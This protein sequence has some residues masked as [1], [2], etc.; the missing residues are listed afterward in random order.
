MRG[1][2]N[3]LRRRWRIVVLVL[4]LSTGL[5]LAYSLST[6]PQYVSSADVLI[7]PSGA[8]IQAGTGTKV[9]SDEMLTQAQVVTS[10]PVARLVKQQLSLSTTPRLADLVTVQTVGTSRILRISALDTSPE[11]AAR[12]ANAVASAYLQY[13]QDE[14]LGSYQQAKK[15]L[16]KEQTNAE[17]QLAKIDA[18][19]KRAS[20]ADAVPLQAERRALI[21]SLA[22]ISQQA[23]GLSQYLTAAAAGGELLEQAAPARRPISPQT[24]LNVI[25]GA[26][27]GMVLGVGAALLRDRFDD[28]VHDEETVRQSLGAVMVGRIPQWSERAH[29]D[30]LVSLSDPH[31]PATEEYRRLGVNVRFMLAPR[32]HEQGALLLTTSGKPREGKTVTSCNLAVALA[33]LGLRVVIVD[34]DLRQASVATRFGLGDPPGLSDLLV[35]DASTFDHLIDVGVDNLQVLAAG[36]PPPNPAALLS[37]ARLGM[38]LSE[39]SAKADLV[40]LDGPPVLNLADALELANRADIVLVVARAGMSRRREMVAVKEA[41]R[42]VEADSVGVVYNGVGDAGRPAYTYGSRARAT[43]ADGGEIEIA[44]GLGEWKEQADRS[45]PTR[46]IRH[47]RWRGRPRGR[48]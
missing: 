34:A 12:T 21:T 1:Y 46:F 23:D 14:S 7:E 15:R 38:V 44:P 11:R 31:A 16:A 36:T 40:I 39:L 4:A 10:A 45:S 43:G 47:V 42:H 18:R 24:T 17:E 28:R 33:N 22:Q 35:G 41:L 3:A 20:R 37:S 26:L 19:L 13:R 27:I 8:D 32:E 25:L 9:D 29:R 2:L 30:R 5:A 6:Q 48:R